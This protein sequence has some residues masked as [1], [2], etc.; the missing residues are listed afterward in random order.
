[1]IDLYFWPTPNGYKTLIALE[2]YGLDYTL[3]PVNIFRGEQ[4]APEFLAISPN[5][6]V[7][8]IVDHA[9]DAGPLAVFE[10]GATLLYLMEKAGALAGLPH[11][12]RYDQL[13]WLFWQMAGLGPMMGQA[14]HFINYAP[15]DI[16]YA[17]NR[18]VSE[19][20]RL[21]GVMEH[22]LADRDFLAGKYSI[23]DMACYPWVRLHQTVF[24]LDIAPFARLSEWLMQV[25]ALPA[26]QRAYDIGE[27]LKAHGLLDQQARH[28]LFNA[29]RTA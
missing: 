10:S 17:R 20:L 1:M 28:H 23:A 8:A 12:Q 19:T 7:P 13:Q 22:R 21:W 2:H 15:E 26:V 24:K 3:K 9:E 5:N 18:Y 25:E 11:A 16:P 29:N 27:P 14:S 6:R 4:F